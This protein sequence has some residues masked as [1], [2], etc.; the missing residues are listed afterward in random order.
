FADV[1]IVDGDLPLLP[2]EDIA[3]QSSVSVNSIIAFDLS[4]VPEGVVI[5]SAELIIQRDSLNTITGSS[6]SNSLLAYFVEDSTTKEVAEE[7]AFLLSFNDNSYSGDITSYVRIWINENRNQGVLLRSGNA[8]EGLELF[9]LKGSTA[10]DFAERPRL[11]I[12][13]TVK[14]NL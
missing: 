1:S 7:G 3:V 4:D 6:F 10:A 14:E 2:Q 11:R 12:V 8:I 13:Y 9:A 5:N